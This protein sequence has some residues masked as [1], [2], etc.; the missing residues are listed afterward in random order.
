MPQTH[1]R[2]IPSLV[3][4]LFSFFLL[5]LL[6]FFFILARPREHR[7]TSQASVMREDEEGD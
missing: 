5:L 1:G 2:D 7:R 4:F 3:S 6:L